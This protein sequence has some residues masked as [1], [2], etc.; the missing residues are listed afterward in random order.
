MP[1]RQRWQGFPVFPSTSTPRRGKASNQRLPHA[2]SKPTTDTLAPGNSTAGTRCIFQ[3]HLPT[4]P[5][6]SALPPKTSR[7]CSPGVSFPHCTDNDDVDAA[8]SLAPASASGVW[9]RQGATGAAA[10][11]RS[12]AAAKN[13]GHQRQEARRTQENNITA[14]ARGSRNRIIV[15]VSSTCERSEVFVRTKT[16]PV[17]VSSF[18]EI[19]TRSVV[20]FR[21]RRSRKISRLFWSRVN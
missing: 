18:S 9:P 6:Q 3:K 7:S 8:V 17:L 12:P 15:K 19:L 5:W 10:K 2:R 21:L 1:G 20:D 16:S 13:T 11:E 4:T 14:V